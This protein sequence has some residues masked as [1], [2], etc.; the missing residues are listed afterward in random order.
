VRQNGSDRR[1]FFF[2]YFPRFSPAVVAFCLFSCC[3]PVLY[4]VEINASNCV[5]N[6]PCP[7]PCLRS[8]PFCWPT[9]IVF[10]ATSTESRRCPPSIRLA[11]KRRRKNYGKILKVTAVK[12]V[13]GKLFLLKVNPK[14]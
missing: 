13:L 6:M 14:A 7:F 10:W 1:P 5:E 12:G 2:L 3:L 4:A 8:L 9:S 11:G